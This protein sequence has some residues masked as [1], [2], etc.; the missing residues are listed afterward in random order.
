MKIVS[1]YNSGQ[2]GLARNKASKFHTTLKKI[3]EDGLKDF[4]SA[5]SLGVRQGI[6]EQ[7]WVQKQVDGFW[8]GE[9]E[10][11][12]LLLEPKEAKINFNDPA[13]ATLVREIHENVKKMNEMD[14]ACT[15]PEK[16]K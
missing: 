6:Y 12:D 9:G 11:I 3:Y 8:V 1:E 5:K 2:K 4:V 10:G 13:V 16:D 14:T 15:E 7:A